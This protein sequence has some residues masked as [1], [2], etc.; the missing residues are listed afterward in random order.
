[1]LRIPPWAHW[2]RLLIWGCFAISA[3]H[4]LSQYWLVFIP[5]LRDPA[6]GLFR[7]PIVS[8]ILTISLIALG[9]VLYWPQTGSIRILIS[10]ITILGLAFALTT[11]NR[12]ANDWS[13][14][15]PEGMAQLQNLIPVGDV[16]YWADSN[17][18][19]W[20]FLKRSSYFGAIQIAGLVFR[21]STAL[22]ADRRSQ[23]LRLLGVRDSLI[24]LQKEQRQSALS[25]MP[26]PSL[27][28]LFSVCQDLS[29]DWIVLRDELTGSIP[30]DS[31]SDGRWFIYH[32]GNYRHPIKHEETLQ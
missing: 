9:A 27:V 26:K 28:G 16:V 31:N 7:W 3:V 20:F 12:S 21:E 1:M 2:W 14:R 18:Y 32:C 30:Y 23:A 25:N 15:D 13:Q 17:H 6:E 11:W 19:T 10:G 29:L 22:E 8:F 5:D 24:T 4:A